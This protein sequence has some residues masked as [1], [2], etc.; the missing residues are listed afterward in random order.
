MW[1]RSRRASPPKRTGRR[2]QALSGAMPRQRVWVSRPF[3]DDLI[4]RLRE[5]FDVETESADRVWT[6][7]EVSAKVR[8][9][10]GVLLGVA[11]PLNAAAVAEAACL[12]AVANVA[13]GYDNV[14][15]A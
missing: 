13:V 3:F 5:F 8:V 2:E 11:D 15:L 4:D 10:H 12:R 14:D 9:K 7:A 6:P 1:A